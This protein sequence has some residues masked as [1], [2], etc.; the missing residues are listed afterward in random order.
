M[1]TAIERK[2]KTGRN[3]RVSTVVSEIDQAG[4]QLSQSKLV[5]TRSVRH[6]A[7]FILL[8]D[9]DGDLVSWSIRIVN[10]EMRVIEI[11]G[12][13]PSNLRYRRQIDD[14]F[15]INIVD[16]EDK[17][18]VGQY[19]R[20]VRDTEFELILPAVL[21]PRMLTIV[22][23]HNQSIINILL[24]E[25]VGNRTIDQDIA[26]DRKC[27]HRVDQLRRTA[28]TILVRQRS[29]VDDRVLPLQ[30]RHSCIVFLNRSMTEHTH[31]RQ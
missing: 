13:P 3:G 30:Q 16:A 9:I 8:N 18:L 12:A 4:F 5:N 31:V 10:S 27:R 25:A 14:R 11:Q 7:T 20:A 2:P 21:K 19:S 15:I 1:S 24:A 6:D 29:I 28:V 26:L 22:V 17:G 23:I